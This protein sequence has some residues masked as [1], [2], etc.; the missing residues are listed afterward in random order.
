MDLDQLEQALGRL[1][2]GGETEV[3][4]GGELLAE[5]TGFRHEVHCR[6]QET[7][8]HLWTSER[9]LVRRVLRVAEST[10]ERL[11]L[12]I[13]RFGQ[14][15]PGRL[16]LRHVSSAS[17]RL[18]RERFRSKFRRFL[19]EQYPDERVDSLSAAPDLQHSF[20]GQYVRGL[21][22][23]GNR[24][25]AVMGVSVVEEPA[26]V[27]AILS[28][29]LLWFDWC[30][31]QRKRRTMVGLRLVVPQGCGPVTAWQLGSLSSR[32]RVDVCELNE[33][34]GRSRPMDLQDTGNIATWLT[35]RREV[36]QTIAAAG[37]AVQDIRQLAPEA[38]DVLVPP[39][40]RELA[41]RFRGL[42]FARWKGG[43]IFFGLEEQPALLTSQ[44]WGEMAALVRELE[45]HRS[46]FS[47][48]RNH[49]MFRA[50]AERWLEA[51]V[52]RDPACIDAHIDPRYL[53]SQVPAFSRGDRG[54]LDLLG[55]TR[56]GRLVVIELKASEDIHLVL[57]AA[58]YW[59][60]VWLHH[61]QGEFPRFGYFQG[62]QLQAKPPL[63]YLVAPGTRFHTSTPVVLRYLSEDIEVSRIGVNENWREGVRV[64]FR[65]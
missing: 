46:P 59:Q 36:E 11:V 8:V 42:E 40:T 28:F 39:G 18:T 10:E 44:N 52:F 57:Q 43:R 3:H 16:E 4:E 20:S 14:K 35:A 37:A 49:T 31:Q 25:W 12:E 47:S 63:L 61:R 29:G 7:L 17:G 48:D 58:D 34:T 13:L 38:I 41:L 15:S 60:R 27:D 51:L 65:M 26:T 45:R 5:L 24:F 33:A 9:N 62:I 19:T 55:V 2:A 30:R 1:L 23:R 6:G 32:V 50:Q 22:A 54:V 64:V 53:Y 21:M 56:D